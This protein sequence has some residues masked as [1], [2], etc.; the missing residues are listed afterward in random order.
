MCER[1]ERHVEKVKPPHDLLQFRKGEKKE[2]YKE[3]I[4]KD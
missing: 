3:M 4:K 2:M 1:S